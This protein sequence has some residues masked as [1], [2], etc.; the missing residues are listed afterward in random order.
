[1]TLDRKAIV[2]R[3]L[4][5]D[6]KYD[7]VQVDLKGRL[8]VPASERDALC[9]I[10]GMSPGGAQIA[11]PDLTPGPG[12]QVVIYIDGFGR[13]EGEVASPTGTTASDGGFEMKFACSSLK[14]ERVAEQLN[15]YLSNG[16]VEESVLRRHD[17]TPSHE[18]TH[19]TR[20]NGDAVN[21]EVLDLSLSGVSLATRLRPP[22]G[23]VVMIGQMSGRV[24]RH[25]ET[26][27]GIEFVRNLRGSASAEAAKAQGR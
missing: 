19:F 11:C 26:G 9:T 14:Q 4:A 5:G 17:R 22:V 7:H 3:A 27:I 15:T 2:A 18:L 12:T 13:F 24:V 21:C 25:H 6:R 10:T 23:E 1:M 16:V 20:A 8:F